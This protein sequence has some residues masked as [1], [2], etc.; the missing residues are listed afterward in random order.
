MNYIEVTYLLTSKKHIEP[1]KKAEELAISLSIGGWG[2]LPENKR[3]KLEKYKAKVTD[4]LPYKEGKKEKIL[5]KIGFPVIL[6][7][8]S[9]ASLLSIIYGKLSFTEEIKIIDIDFHPSFLDHFQGPRYGIKGIR[10]LLGI[11]HEPLLMTVIKPSVGLNTDEFAEEFF[12]HAVGEADLVKDDEIFFDDALAPFEKRIEA[13]VKKAEEA[14]KITGR[15][16]LY[17]PHL[18]G[19]VNQLIEKA[20]RGVEAGAKGFLV[21]VIPYGFDILQRLS[22]EVD[23]FFVAH[24]SFSGIIF[25]SEHIGIRSPILFGKLMRLMGADIVIYPSPYKKNI[26]G[27]TD[28]MEIAE[29][30]RKDWENIN[31]S[32][33]AL[34]GNI[35]ALNIH[36]A[37]KD[38]G[39]QTIFVASGEI[40]NHPDGAK[41]GVEALRDA[42]DCTL[43][44]V[45]LE[46]CAAASPSLEK[47]LKVYK[48]HE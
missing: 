16:T 37:F 17:I 15:K 29:N 9:V 13:C 43:T 6:F 24:P 45:T 46:E 27:H 44:G 31:P 5:M 42:L 20:K 33:P 8:H 41:D 12:K 3:K 4:V 47:A 38:F 19:K 10:E 2:D 36:K 25:K 26:I 1:E 32:F 14:E 7:E 35:T 30:L 48:E 22:E 28:A 34:I 21:N 11:H 18:K 40:Y 39:N 23:A